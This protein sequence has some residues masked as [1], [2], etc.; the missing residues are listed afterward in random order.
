MITVRGYKNRTKHKRKR[1]EK[2]IETIEYT[3]KRI[4]YGDVD[5]YG[6]MKFMAMQGRLCCRTRDL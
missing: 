5:G 3:A 2:E 6:F 1:E 4:T